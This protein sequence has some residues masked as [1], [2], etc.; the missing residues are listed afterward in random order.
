MDTHVR[1]QVSFGS[2]RPGTNSAL[3]G[4]FSGMCPVMHL[5]CRLARQ[6]PMAYDTLIGVGQ[7]VFDVIHQL[8]EFGSIA[9]FFDLD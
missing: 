5:K 3:E 6:N 1:F 8:F 7:L 2:K 4:T 9:G